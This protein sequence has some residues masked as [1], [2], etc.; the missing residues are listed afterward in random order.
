ME[1]FSSILQVGFFQKHL[2]LGI[3]SYSQM[4]LGMSNQLLSIVFRFH[5][6]ILRSC[7]G[8][9][10]L[11]SPRTLFDHRDGNEC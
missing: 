1:T 4:M 9:Q 7:F 2:T 8:C 5:E 11:E 6:T 3:Q 10:G